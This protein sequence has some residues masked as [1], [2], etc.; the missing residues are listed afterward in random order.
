MVQR[1]QLK[2]LENCA[3]RDDSWLTVKRTLLTLAVTSLLATTAFAGPIHDAAENGD[4][5]G[6]VAELDKGVD[7]NAKDADGQTPLHFATEEGH[8][9]I[10]E[11]L[12]DKGADVDGKDKYGNTP[13]H[14]AATWG[15]KE[16][17]ELLI[18]NDADVNAKNKFG[19]TPL[20]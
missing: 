10:V 11:L 13:L 8:K 16:T 14:Y 20:D 2:S 12:I 17:A 19:E 5:R 9:E 1:Q 7:A 3:Q 18:A 4:A 6:V 15:H